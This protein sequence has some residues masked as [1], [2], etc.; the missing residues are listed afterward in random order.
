M[1]I[2]EPT[3][4]PD[5]D[6]SMVLETI[7]ALNRWNQ[8]NS[9]HHTEKRSVERLGYDGR[10]LVVIDATQDDSG[11]PFADG[12]PVVFRAWG[13]DL[14][15]AGMSFL[16]P[17]RLIS[18]KPGDHSPAV[19]LFSQM[20]ELG[21]QFRIGLSQSKGDMLFMTALLIRL[22][23]VQNGMIDCG[24]RFLDRTDPPTSPESGPLE[25]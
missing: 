12:G 3:Y 11:A 6:E 18:C 13:R 10:P 2:N 4:E 20:V 24:V 19:L 17:S 9:G 15:R 8:I 1:R 21:S 5:C 23:L 7:T 22:R 16:T 14:S 25:S